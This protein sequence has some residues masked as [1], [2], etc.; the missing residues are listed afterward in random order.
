MVAVSAGTARLLV[1]LALLALWEIGAR[2]F[3][4]PSFLCPPSDALLAARTILGDPKIVA[5]ILLTLYEVLV[6]FVVAVPAGALIGIA[7]G[8]QRFTRAAF[9][10]VVLLLYVIPQATLLPLFV[11]AFGIGPAAKIVF[12]ITHGVFP[13]IVTTVASVQNVPAP[14]LTAARSM[15]AGRVG[16]FREVLFPHMVPSFFT[17]M[18]LS[19]AAVLLAVI[20]AELYVSTA[21]IGFYTRLFAQNFSPPKLFA[22]MG[23]LAAIAVTLNE[24]CRVAERRFSR[25]RYV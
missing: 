16:C 14:L 19:M 6:A 25:W 11:L 3:G 24:G 1:I 12:G 22:L 7:V 2:L 13:M 8:Q 20:F 15:G 9:M 4:N 17:G 18:R 23:V 21:G 10:P 5:A